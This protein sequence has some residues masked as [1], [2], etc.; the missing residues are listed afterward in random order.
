MSSN[1]SKVGGFLSEDSSKLDIN[2]SVLFKAG[3][4]LSVNILIGLVG[5]NSTY[6]LV[7]HI[8]DC[9]GTCSSTIFYYV[10]SMTYHLEMSTMWIH[11]NFLSFD[12]VRTSLTPFLLVVELSNHRRLPIHK[13]TY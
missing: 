6:A 2:K 4:P 12:Q 13:Y 3:V 5:Y 9:F 7:Y 10:N 1:I 8:M 11:W